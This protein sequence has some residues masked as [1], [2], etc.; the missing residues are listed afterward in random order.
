MCRKSTDLTWEE[1]EL[2]AA[3]AGEVPRQPLWIPLPSPK[4]RLWRRP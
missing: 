3:V 4:L 1:D 2:N